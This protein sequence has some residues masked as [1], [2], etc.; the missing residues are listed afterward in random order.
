MSITRRDLLK[1][2]AAG[3]AWAALGQRAAPAAEQLAPRR[4]G[5]PKVAMCDWSLGKTGDVAAI[6][7]ARE[8]GLDGVEV[9]INFPGPGQHLRDTAVQ[10]Q[11]IGA[12]KRSRVAAPSVALGI[13][14]GVPL[15]SE[16]KAAI[17]LADAIEVARA[18]GAK[19][20]LVAFFGDGELKMGNDQ[21]INRTV[22]VLR[23]LAPRAARARVALGLEN[24]LSAEDNLRLLD[25]VGSDW[26]QVYYDCKN[27]ADL[28]RDAAA[29]IRALGRRIC[30]VHL[31]NGAEFLSG[32]S[33]VNFAACADA[34]RAVGYRGWYVLETTN[35]SGDVIADTGANADYV[36]R[37]FA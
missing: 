12:L 14:N 2:A 33:N 23:E 26:V 21:E 28:G 19:V 34:L 29:E 11:F 32:P 18:L 16:P 7:L 37:V 5:A 9:S 3:A 36:R 27:S 24:T 30:Q 13:L 20:I 35:P 1:A 22:D 4:V 31:K 8:A 25:R 17:W 15:K 10:R 6:N